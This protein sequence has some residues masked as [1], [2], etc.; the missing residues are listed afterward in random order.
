VV[1]RLGRAGV[2][3]SQR[4]D[5]VRFSPHLYNIEADVDRAVG[6]LRRIGVS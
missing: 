2:I 5:L 4:R 3:V 1:R 6:E